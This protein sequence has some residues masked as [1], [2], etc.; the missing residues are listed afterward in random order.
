MTNKKNLQM[1]SFDV[2]YM[3]TYP[4]DSHH[5]WYLTLGDAYYPNKGAP[6]AQI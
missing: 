1:D 5:K 4:V 2:I 3:P 6:L